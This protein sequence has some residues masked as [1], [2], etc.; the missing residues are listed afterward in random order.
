MG[1]DDL[2]TLW[3]SAGGQAPDHWKFHKIEDLLKN[4]KSISVGV[5]YPGQN[6]PGGIPLIRVTDVKSGSI[7]SKPTF[8]ISPEVDEEYKRT[9]LNGTELL[10]T[11]VGNPGDCVV[12]STTMAGWNAAR[13]LAVVRL[14]DTNLR[15]WLRY[16]LLS[17]PAKHLIDV[18]LNTT[19]QKTLNLKDIR[20]LG[21]PI[22]PKNERDAISSFISALD[23]KI[24]LNRRMNETLEGLA[25]ALFKSWFVDF[26]PVI[27]NALAAG[28][29]IPDELEER[30]EVR[31]QA[32]ADGSANREAARAF[33]AGFQFT[34]EMGWVPEGWGVEPMREHLY[35]TKGLSYKGSGLSDQ[36][37][38]LHN[39]NS[40]YE[41]GGY[42]YEG[43]KYYSGDF[44]GRNLIAPGEV[45]VANTEQG[46]D[47]LLLGFAAI[48]PKCFGSS[49]LYS[50]HLYKL[51]PA[52][53][54]P[55]SN[56]YIV[57][58]LNT[59]LY[60]Q[61]V[62]GYGNGTTVNML[63]IDALQMPLICIPPVEVIQSFDSLAVPMADRKE[64]LIEESNIL[65]NLRDTLLPKL[66]SGELRVPDAAKLAEEA[67]T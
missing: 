40:V 67:L 42:K 44:K 47:R 23:D 62:S 54:S 27:D 52:A 32:L 15:H 63:P 1:S 58:L 61:I 64:S 5:M 36:G 8:C 50:H 53:H 10:I 41:G 17:A 66:I 49:G 22:P 60:H 11:L 29:P 12:A 7:F 55:L 57:S 21:I 18:R 48:V 56:H 3:E 33:P 37:I 4:S 20:L 16:I 28:N 51:S 14:A 2:R 9:R 6:S 25:Q 46:H 59:S 13:A 26:D 24:E 31:R 45:V 35:A 19:V 39:L 43:I 30:A 34:E 38:P 65:T